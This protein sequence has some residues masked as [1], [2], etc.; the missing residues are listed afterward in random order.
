MGKGS[1]FGQVTKWTVIGDTVT[2]VQKPCI[3]FRIL[4]RHLADCLGHHQFPIDDEVSDIADILSDV[5]IHHELTRQIIRE[6]YKANHCG[7]LDAPIRLQPTLK[8][9]GRIQGEVLR[10]RHSDVDIVRYFSELVNSV[11]EVLSVEQESPA[12]NIV[13]HKTNRSAIIRPLA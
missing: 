9:L 8:T 6:L 5:A 12:A 13:R 11:S 7:F 2:V 1:K 3:T 4:M 10:S